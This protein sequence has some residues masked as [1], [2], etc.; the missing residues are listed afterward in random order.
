VAAGQPEG[1]PGKPGK[2]TSLNQS[3]SR[4]SFLA[5]G[6]GA[7]AWAFAPAF[8][9]SPDL[10][11]QT[12]KKASELLRSKKASPVELTRACLKRIEKLNPAVNAFITVT[13]E[14][15]LAAAR[16]METE[17]QRGRWRG[18]LHGIPIALKDNID[19]AGVRTTGAS[20]LFKDRI[21]TEDAEVVRRLKN[22]GAVLLGKLNMHE[23]AYGASSAVS[24]FGPV[25]NPWALDRISGGSSGGSAASIAAGLCFGTLGTDT[26]GSIRIPS[27]HCGVA[28]LM[29][30]YGR[31]SN[32]GVIPMAWTL[33]HVGPICK[34]V[35]DAA[36]MLGIVA[37]YDELDPAA[38][39]V[40]V[41]GYTRALKTPVS[42]LRLGLPRAGFFDG[43]DPEYAKAVDAAIE[44]LRKL[45][46]SITDVQLPTAVAAQLIWGPETYAYHAKWLTESPEKYQA[47]TRAQMIR[48]NEIKPDVY[49]EARR[50]VDW[51]RREIKKT[52]T[53]VDLLITPT[54]KGPPATIAASQNPPAPPP[55]ANG[56]AP[57]NLGGGNSNSPGAFD[58]YGL[59]AIT[60]PC[61]FTNSGLPIG[62]QISGAPFAETAML[63]LA[64]AYEQATE[65]HTRRPALGAS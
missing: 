24:Y 5:A 31:V 39:N 23:F 8:A 57:R 50:Q 7:A 30:T 18:P 60:V 55:A 43:L 64:H 61:G 58:V 15:A 37:G 16:E 54:M 9:E 11:A 10:T 45:T 4:R 6:A 36:L 3:D 27:S 65:W 62:L 33:D 26:G 17:A 46:A 20:E 53:A 19:T 63:A 51:A 41:P 38:V 22:A 1:R 48:S 2:E 52:F 34:T 42:K 21:P 12:L 32:R 13:G 28:G 49:A 25:H 44:V 14:S 47:A 56:V 29:P 35:E 40:P 59:P